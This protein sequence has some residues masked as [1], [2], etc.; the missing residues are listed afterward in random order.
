MDKGKKEGVNDYDVRFEE[1]DFK[2]LLRLNEDKETMKEE[3]AD[4]SRVAAVSQMN[5]RLYNTFLSP[6]VKAFS[7]EVTVEILKQLHPLRVNKYIFS[8]SINPFMQIFNMLS[9]VVKKNRK[10]VSPDNPFG[11]VEKNISESIVALMDSFQN[12]RDQLDENLFFL[13]YE[14]PFI[15]ALS[16]GPMLDKMPVMEPEKHR[17]TKN[18]SKLLRSLFVL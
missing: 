13:I 1:R 8:D 15:K 3:E 5:D 9:P 2:D 12:I 11:A 7:T 16:P 14:N 18:K 6:F 4:F 17:M 10:Q